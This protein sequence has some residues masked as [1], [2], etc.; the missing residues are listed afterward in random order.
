MCGLWCTSVTADTLK[1]MNELLPSK[2]TSARRVLLV[3]DVSRWHSIYQT[4]L[5]DDLG[6]EVITIGNGAD[7]L[8]FLEQNGCVNLMLLDLN[9]PGMKG[10]EVLRMVRAKREYDQ[11]PVIIITGDAASETQERLLE[12]GANDFVDKGAPYGVLLARAKA[13]LRHMDLMD[14]L[15]GIAMDLDVFSAGILHDMH[16]LEQGLI[17]YCYLMGTRV[18]ELPEGEMK[19]GLRSDIKAIE[20]QLRC[21][22]TYAKDVIQT[23]KSSS[24]RASLEEA[25]WETV[26]GW[27]K[28]TVNA[29]LRGNGDAA[30]EVILPDQ[31]INVRGRKQLMNLI[32]LNLL[33]NSFKYR[34]RESDP[35]VK[36][37]QEIKAIEGRK[38][39]VTKF[40]DHGTGVHPEELAKVFQPFVRSTNIATNQKGFGLG[41]ALVSKAVRSMEGA[42]WA[43]LPE[44]GGHGAVFAVALPE[45]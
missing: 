17:G 22:G 45:A 13:Q 7:A 35:C 12:A 6:C 23:V 43:E 32:A 4:A 18:D 21:L 39:V 1:N 25:S 15:T 8:K 36:L 38:M 24:D 44:D 9:M 37:S 34:R 14:Q 16:N 10:E 19:V 42:V 20:D 31:W 26:V 28:G 40:R 30:I 41:L 5:Q 27:A 29:A 33:Q 3:D 2:S 11:M